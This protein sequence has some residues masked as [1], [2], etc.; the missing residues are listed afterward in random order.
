MPHHGVKEKESNLL[1]LSLMD[2]LIK[3]V[4]R[5]CKYPLLI[6]Q[7][8]TTRRIGPANRGRSGRGSL[9]LVQSAMQAMR[10]VVSAVDEATYS[11]I[12]SHISRTLASPLP[13]TSGMTLMYSHVGFLNTLI[14]QCSRARC[15]M[16]SGLSLDKCRQELKC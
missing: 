13:V 1:R 16:V 11:L 12:V 8:K 5:I 9:Q 2:Y 7:L 14:L 15:N 10:L 3:P 6:S 4:Q